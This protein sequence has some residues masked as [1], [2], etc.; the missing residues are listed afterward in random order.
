MYLTERIQSQ[1]TAMGHQRSVNCTMLAFHKYPSL[2]LLPALRQLG[3]DD[4]RTRRRAGHI[5]V[6]ENVL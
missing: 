2:G 6:C 5:L 1:P 4:V 3:L